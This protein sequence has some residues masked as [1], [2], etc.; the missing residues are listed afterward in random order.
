VFNFISARN[1]SNVLEI[2]QRGIGMKIGIIG[3]G[4]VGRSHAAKLTE[5]GHDVVIGTRNVQRTLEK[6]QKDARGNPPMKEWIRNNP[7]VKLETFHEAAK[8]GELIINATKGEHSLEALRMSGEK[9]L[10]GKI[11]LDISNPLDFSEGMPPSLLISNTD[12][13]A[14]QIQRGFPNAM[15]VKTLNTINAMVQ[16]NPRALMAGDHDVFVSGNISIAKQQVE[17]ILRSYGWKNIIDLGDIS[18]A[19]GAEMMLPMWV[20]L[21]DALKTPMFNFKIVR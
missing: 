12:S 1:I 19:R 7:G 2:L 8:H 21:M 3:T 10:T 15:V 9:N 6:T 11:I 5:L 17:E 4:I 18:T 14:E 16:V 20:R 13:L